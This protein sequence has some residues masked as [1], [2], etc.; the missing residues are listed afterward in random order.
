[1]TV[2]V[3]PSIAELPLIDS[4]T[5]TIDDSASSDTRWTKTLIMR[6]IHIARCDTNQ[7]DHIHLYIYTWKHLILYL[8]DP[9]VSVG[10]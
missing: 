5:Y 1:M 8:L 9:Y 7:Q 4:G 10:L 2:E 6:N 3:P